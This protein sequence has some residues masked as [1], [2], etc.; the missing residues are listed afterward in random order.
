MTINY[1]GNF[2]SA[3][4][5]EV[6][7]VVIHPSIPGAFAH[8]PGTAVIALQQVLPGESSPFQKFIPGPDTANHKWGLLSLE[9]GF[10]NQFN[11]TGLWWSEDLYDQYDVAYH[12]NEYWLA[13][14]NNS[15]TEPGV[16]HGAWYRLAQ[17][18]ATEGPVGPEGP[19][20]PS[21]VQGVQGPQGDQGAQGNDGLQG[22]TGSPGNDGST[23]A[24][25]IQGLTGMQGD[26]GVQGIQGLTGTQGVDGSQGIQGLTGVQG[27]DGDTGPQGPKGD[28]GASVAG[29]VQIEPDS[30]PHTLLPGVRTLYLMGSS[31]G[32]IL[33]ALSSAQGTYVTVIRTSG[34][35]MTVS[36][37]GSDLIND[38]AS[39][40]VMPTGTYMFTIYAGPTSWYV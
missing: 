5:Y 31:G 25:G 7:D 19:P 22:L 40:R 27:V 37:D 30:G 29:S 20:G 15:D 24:Q 8:E 21:G 18:V 4:T 14:I 3:D 6:N 36:R 23:G 17:V 39:T 9:V 10:T 38:L 34:S 13:L 1:R 26:P 28:N 2:N 33:P 11:Y 35:S 12:N 16:E 32:I